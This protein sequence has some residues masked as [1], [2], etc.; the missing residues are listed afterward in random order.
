QLRGYAYF[1]AD[2]S[3]GEPTADEVLA[4]TSVPAD[5]RVVVVGGVDERAAGL[6]EA[7]EDGE[8]GVHVGACAEVHRAEADGGDVERGA[9][10]ADG[11]VAHA[12][13]FRSLR[14]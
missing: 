4:V 1:G 9:S 11:A 3:V 2:A 13:S 14:V 6:D 12:G 8:R 7:V 10:V 5:P